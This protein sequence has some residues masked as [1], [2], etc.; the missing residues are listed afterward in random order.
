M[1]ESSFCEVDDLG[2]YLIVTCDDKTAV[3]SAQRVTRR[4]GLHETVGLVLEIG[5]VNIVTST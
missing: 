5:G 1:G 3:R 4:K 2:M